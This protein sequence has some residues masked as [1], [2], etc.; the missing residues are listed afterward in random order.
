MTEQIEMTISTIFS[1]GELKNMFKMYC[2]KERSPEGYEFLDQLEKFKKTKSEHKRYTK[3][4][5]IFNNFIIK[6]SPLELNLTKEIIQQVEK[7]LTCPFPGLDPSVPTTF[8][9]EVERQVAFNLQDILM[10]F[11]NTKEVKNYSQKLSEKSLKL[12]PNSPRSQRSYSQPSLSPKLKPLQLNGTT[13]T[14]PT[15][16][17][18]SFFE[19]LLVKRKSSYDHQEVKKS[20]PNTPGRKNFLESFVSISLHDLMPEDVNPQEDSDEKIPKTNSNPEMEKTPSD[21]EFKK[22]N[23]NPEMQLKEEPKEVTREKTQKLQEQFDNLHL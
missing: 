2:T 5:E 13:Q 21:P 22:T 19:D 3:A 8:F 23:S 6:D 17:K 1:D 20:S 10:R 18:K 16:P 11:I 12:I 9:S 4:K 7:N 15:S 14:G